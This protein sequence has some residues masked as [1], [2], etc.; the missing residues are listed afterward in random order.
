MEMSRKFYSS[1]HRWSLEISPTTVWSHDTQHADLDTNHQNKIEL[2]EKSRKLNNTLHNVRT[3]LHEQT[4]THFFRIA[5]LFSVHSIHLQT[6]KNTS[7][8][9]D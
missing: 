5:A 6:F 3:G 2:I 4:V 1:G 8:I 9:L 7:S